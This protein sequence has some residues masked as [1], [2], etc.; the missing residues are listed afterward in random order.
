MNQED[1]VEKGA[2]VRLMGDIFATALEVWA[3][4]GEADSTIVELV[5]WYDKSFHSTACR[6]LDRVSRRNLVLEKD[7]PHRWEQWLAFWSR[8]YWQRAWIVQELALAQSIRVLCG[9]YFLLWT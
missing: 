9:S 4:I 7:R 6:V 5:R 8:P 3:C 1:A 2:Q